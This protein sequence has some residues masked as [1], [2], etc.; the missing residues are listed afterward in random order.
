MLRLSR[1]EMQHLDKCVRKTTFSREGYVR[2]LIAGYEPQSTPPAE[3]YDIIR[4]LRKIDSELRR[5]ADT[6]PPTN[7]DSAAF[8]ASVTKRCTSACDRLQS[9]FVPKPAR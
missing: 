7:I 3:Y 8:F 5:Y 1:D 4:E 2:K 9:M 6:I